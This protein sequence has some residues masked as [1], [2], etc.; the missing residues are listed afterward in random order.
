MAGCGLT[1]IALELLSPQKKISV[2]LLVLGL[3]ILL[4]SWIMDEG[5]KIQEEQ[6]LTV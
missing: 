6:E 2:N 4:I 1:Q 3:L 5:R